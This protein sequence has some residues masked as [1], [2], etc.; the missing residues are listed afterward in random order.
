M[1]DQLKDIREEF[2][3]LDDKWTKPIEERKIDMRY[4][5]GDPW[6][7]KDR[8]AREDAGR[9]CLNHDELRQ[10]VNQ[11]INS[12]RQ[13]KRGIK[14][15]PDGKGSNEKSAELR[16]DLIRTI[17]YKSGAP[18]IYISSGFEQAIRGGYGFFRIGRRY[19]GK[20]MDQE[21]TIKPFLNPD[22]VRFDWDCREVDWSDARRAFV[23]DW[24][25]KDEFKKKYPKAEITNFTAEHRTMASDWVHEDKVLVAEYWKVECATTKIY[26]IM[27]PDGKKIIVDQK[28][29]YGVQVITSR[30]Y[31]EKTVIQRITNG[32]EIIKKIPQ[33][34][35]IIPIIPVIGEEI[36]IDEGKGTER[37]LI[38]LPRLA[39]DPQMSLAYLVSQMAEEAKLTPK[40]PFMGYKGQFESDHERWEKLTSEGSAYLQ[41]DPVVDGASGQ[42]LPLPT[43]LQFTPNFSQ[44]IVAEDSCRRAVQAAMGIS[45]LPTA[46]QRQNEKSGIALERIQ[47]SQTIGSFHFNDRFDMFLCLAGKVMNSWIDVV[48]NTEQEL[49]LRKA[50]DTTYKAKLNTEQP[51]IDEKNQEKQYKIEE[52]QHHITI[53]TGPSNQSQ[54][55]EVADFLDLIISNLK[56][57]PIPPEQQAKM[58]AIM[59]R[60]KNMGPRGDE[61][62]DII[63]PKQEGAQLPPEAQQQIQ[64][65]MQ[66]IQALDNYG[67]QKEQEIEELNQKLQGQVIN[68]EYKIKLENLKIEA[69]LAKAEIT[70]KAQRLEERLTFVE[71]MFKQ[72]HSQQ[73]ESSLQANQQEH[74]RTLADQQVAAQAQQQS[75]ESQASGAEPE[76]QPAQEGA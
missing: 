7:P 8:K 4:L 51:Y 29:G 9:P 71:D 36:W 64:Q 72:I 20:T 49:T 28:P 2:A 65:L 53:S 59:I 33:P 50:D 23:L 32:V 70:T 1:D 60:M 47:Q 25:L 16:Q 76:G 46:A 61:L 37:V 63:S 55:E 62:A 5:M 66:K 24:V 52:S 11:A 18:Y 45:P 15:D 74:E 38:S 13:N 17:E 43:R 67:Q 75:A 6:D 19:V 58:I 21:I 57:L 27:G 48:Y 69:D 73:H 10:Y 56:T 30:D 14:V 3:Y 54:R 41:V 44:Y 42:V 12:M 31:E 34:G 40:S 35:E 26:Q 22:A 68:N 39:R